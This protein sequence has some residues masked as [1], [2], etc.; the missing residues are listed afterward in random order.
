MSL[1]LLLGWS[2]LQDGISDLKM[3]RPLAFL[4]SNVAS[5]GSDSRLIGPTIDGVRSLSAY[6]ACV[7]QLQPPDISPPAEAEFVPTFD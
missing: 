2:V 4:D 6:R 7:L 1:Y 5:N 3:S